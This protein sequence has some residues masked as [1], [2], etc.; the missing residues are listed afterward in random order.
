MS[1]D[2]MAMLWEHIQKQH[3]SLTADGGTKL[4]R[5]RPCFV[6][7]SFLAHPANKSKKATKRTTFHGAVR[8]RCHN[9]KVTNDAIHPETQRTTRPTPPPRRSDR[10]VKDTASR[11]CSV[12]DPLR[13]DAHQ[14][15]LPAAQR[16]LAAHHASEQ[17]GRSLQFPRYR[18]GASN[19]HAG[20]IQ[21][22]RQRM[23]ACPMK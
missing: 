13:R 9:P 11:L 19:Y 15:H 5:S 18:H 1:L 6:T 21:R 3:I 23:R 20:A 12:S 7:R 22:P 10:K 2:H 16:V 8:R 14:V 4:T 17:R